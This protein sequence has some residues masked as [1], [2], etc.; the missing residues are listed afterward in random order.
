MT[1]LV[2]AGS[3]LKRHRVEQP[4]VDFSDLCPG[5]EFFLTRNLI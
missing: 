4:Q 3:I 5:L 2:L 1:G